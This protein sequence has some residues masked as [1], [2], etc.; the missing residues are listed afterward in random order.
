MRNLKK[1]IIFFQIRKKKDLLGVDDIWFE[2]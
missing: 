1:K 2:R